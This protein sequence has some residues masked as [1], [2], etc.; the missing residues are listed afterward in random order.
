MELGLQVDFH[1][2]IDIRY[3][4]EI[5]LERLTILVGE[6]GVGVRHY[7]ETRLKVEGEMAGCTKLDLHAAGQ[8][9]VPLVQSDVRTGLLETAGLKTEENRH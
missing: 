9:A 3:R 8:T 4:V 6:T 7:R 1:A 2:E 5:I